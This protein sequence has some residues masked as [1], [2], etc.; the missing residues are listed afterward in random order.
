MFITAIVVHMIFGKKLILASN[1]SSRYK[2]LKNAGLSIN[3]TKP[4]CNEE[5]IKKKLLDKKINIKN[6]P[7]YLAKEKA[8]SISENKPNS[9]V[10][11]SDTIIIFQNQIINKAKNIKEAKKKIKKT[12]WKKT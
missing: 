9:F 3:K 11:G 2:I 1:S 12:I 5:A 7:K 4:L 10:I 6:I 8:L